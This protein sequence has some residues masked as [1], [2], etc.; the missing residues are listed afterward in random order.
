MDESAIQG[1][2]QGRTDAAVILEVKGQ[3]QQIPFAEFSACS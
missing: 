2:L 3:V 1:I